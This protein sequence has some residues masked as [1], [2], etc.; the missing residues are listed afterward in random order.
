MPR[1]SQ[2]M[3]SR[4]TDVIGSCDLCYQAATATNIYL[5]PESEI[6]VLLNEF[7]KVDQLFLEITSKISSSK[8]VQKTLINQIF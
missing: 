5:P 7:E 1:Y 3:W 8:S 2:L 6:T 4:K